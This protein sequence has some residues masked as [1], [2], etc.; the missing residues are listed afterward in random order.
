[1]V[2]V[3]VFIFVNLFVTILLNNFEVE[4]EEEDEDNE[5]FITQSMAKL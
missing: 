1:M 3:G 5:D 2:I 4:D